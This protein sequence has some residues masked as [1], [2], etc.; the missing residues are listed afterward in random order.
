MSAVKTKGIRNVFDKLMATIWLL[1]CMFP[2]YWLATTSLKI[3]RDAFSAKFFFSPTLNNYSI[4]FGDLYKAGPRFMNSVIVS[5]CVVLIAIPVA[6]MAAYVFSRFEFKGSR[7]MMV[8]ILSCQFI[9]PIVIVMPYYTIFSK[10]KLID[11]KLALVIITLSMALPY[12]IW[13]LKGF[14]DAMPTEIE[15][16][17]YIDGCSSLQTLR[18]VVIPLIMPGII[19]TVVFC[20]IMAWNEFLFA[21]ILTR[22]TSKTLTV[23]LMSAIN[24]KGVQWE[25]MSAMG[26][27]VMVP[28]FVLSFS[29]RKYFVQGMTM[30][31]IK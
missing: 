18:Y 4:V 5:V 27:M 12:S 24:N 29:I 19:T 8:Y 23:G 28:V 14:V 1:F 13:L 26:V 7:L 25:L 15:E 17:A 16:A 22:E 6:V 10:L 20:F 2:I 11:T 3:E 30:G 9:P 21:L 31:G